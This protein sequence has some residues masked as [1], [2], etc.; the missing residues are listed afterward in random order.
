MNKNDHP[1]YN[2]WWAVKM[3][4]TNPA[5]KGYANWGGRGIDVCSE[6]FYD[7]WAYATYVEALD[8]YGRE[9]YTLDR[10]DNDGDY[11]PGNVRWADRSTQN[12]NKRGSLSDE[13]IKEIILKH[14]IFGGNNT[15]VERLR[16]LGYK[17]SV[18]RFQK[19]R[20]EVQASV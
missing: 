18:N 8:N 7:F 14:E 9:G 16:A 13:D 4:C 5:V 1:C 17:C 6:W 20:N 12:L 2:R 11:E 10:I 19:L 3:R 15:G